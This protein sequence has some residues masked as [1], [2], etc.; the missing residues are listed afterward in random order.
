MNV[1]LESFN[2][3]FFILNAMKIEKENF[4]MEIY[5]EDKKKNKNYIIKMR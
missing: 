5:K 3:T 2:E 4:K 1:K